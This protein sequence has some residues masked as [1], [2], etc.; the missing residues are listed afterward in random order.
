MTRKQVARLLAAVACLGFLGTAGLHSTGYD[1]AVRL[2]EQVPGVIGEVIP[3]IWLAFSIDLAVIG[4]IVGILVVRPR[5]VAR[6]ILVVSS[7]CPFAAAGLQLASIGFVPPTAILIGLG[8]V[9]LA[10]AVVWPGDSQ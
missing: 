7:I 1:S 3:M 9:T 5:D 8:I 6:P 2:A 4:L 10:G